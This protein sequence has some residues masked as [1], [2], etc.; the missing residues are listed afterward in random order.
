MGEAAVVVWKNRSPLAGSRVGETQWQLEGMQELPQILGTA[1]PLRYLQQLPAVQTSS[2]YDSGIHVQ[3]LGTGHNAYLIGYAPVYNPSHLLGI[4][5]AFN[6]AHFQ[7]MSL[8]TQ[9]RAS[10]PARLGG[11]VELHSTL[12]S[13]TATFRRPTVQRASLNAG[14]MASEATLGAWL[15]KRLSVTASVRQAYM[16]LLYSPWLK[17]DGSQLHY[18]FGDYN[19]SFA[20]RATACHTLRLEAYHGRDNA[21]YFEARH[22]AAVSVKWHNTAMS[23]AHTYRRGSTNFSQHLSLAAYANRLRLDQAGQSLDVPSHIRSLSYGAMVEARHLSAGVGYTCYDV[24]PQAP[25]TER[26]FH[27]DMASQ[28]A[29]HSHEATAYA[30]WQAQWQRRAWWQLTASMKGIVFVPRGEKGMFLPSPTVSLTCRP[31]A[32]HSLMLQVG[33]LQQPL[34]FTGFTSLGL[35]IEFYLPASAAHRAERAEAVSLHYEGALRDG[36]WR[37][38][39]SAYFKRLHHQVE[40]N[41]NV[42]SL[43]TATYNLDAS[44]LQGS[45][46]TYGFGFQLTRCT[47]PVTGWVGYSWG[48]SLRRFSTAEFSGTY[49]AAFER[50]HEVNLMAAWRVGRRFRLSLSGV[51]ASGTPFTSARG[52]YLMNGYLITLYGEHNACRLRWY[53]RLDVALNH[54]F[55]PKAHHRFRH[56]MNYSVFN[57]FGFNNDLFYRLR[58]RDDGYRFVPVSFLKYPLPSISYFL[59]F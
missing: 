8:T 50:T 21:R 46:R 22:Q 33:V 55:R 37:L 39:A 48:R 16:N 20:L 36:A 29:L 41:D 31:T 58:L 44:L 30:Q 10:Q 45:G 32:Y 15:T 2:E 23:L 25:E 38:S 49:P 19:L 43:L 53:K 42:L 26:S 34:H 54:E 7:S 40:L 17:F 47:G 5:S 59:N 13:D 9:P 35:P 51:A 3:G 18:D 27:T 4:F 1:N 11:I 56:G 24:L 14:P 28:P 12:P 52:A 57:L 6:T